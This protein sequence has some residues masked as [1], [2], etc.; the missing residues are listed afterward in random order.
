MSRIALAFETLTPVQ[1]CEIFGRALD[2]PCKYV[3]DHHIEIK[4]PVPNVYRQQLAGIEVLFGMYNA[5]YYPGPD[6]EYSARRKGS[7]DTITGKSSHESLRKGKPGKITDDA[8]RLWPGWR[9]LSEYV[10]TAFIVE[11]EANGKTWMA[12]K[13][14]ST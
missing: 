8:R 4:V 9:S 1:V 7:N 11:E 12:D 13:T 5:P 14:V 2:R 10:S 6:F 3:F